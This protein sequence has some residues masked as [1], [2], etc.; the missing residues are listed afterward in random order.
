[1]LRTLRSSAISLIGIFFPVKSVILATLALVLAD[2]ITGL[3]AAKKRG[4]SLNSAG[5]RRTVTKICVYEAAVCL[6]FLAEQYLTGPGIPLAKWVASFIGITEFT[7]I[8]EN[9]NSISGGQLL[10]S[11]IAR[12]GSVNDSRK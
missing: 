7:S 10:S 1:M 4:E 2:L 6:G 12:L 9:L 11:L 8:A 5:L 3:I